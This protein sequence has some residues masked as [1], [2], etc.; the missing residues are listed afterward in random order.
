MPA[1]PDVSWPSTVALVGKKADIDGVLDAAGWRED[2]PAIVDAPEAIAMGEHPAMA[3]RRKPNSSISVALREVRSGRAAA[4][5][6]AGNSG[7]VMAGALVELGRIAGV[8]RPAIATVM[9]T[10]TG[11]TIL[12]DLGAVTDPKPEFLVQF[13]RMAR[14]YAQV[15]FG[16][17]DPKIALLSNGEEA[18]KGNQLAREAHALL[19]SADGITFIGNCEANVIIRG[20][21]DIIV[22]DGFT[23]NVTLKAIE[24]ANSIFSDLIRQ[25]L[26]ANL[27]RK[28]L[29]AGLRPA[30]RAIRRRFDFAEIGG[31]PL[32][33]VNGV[34]IIAHGRS[35]ARAIRNAIRVA[36][37]AARQ[38]LP[39]RIAEAL[40]ETAA[41]SGAGGR[42]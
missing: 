9:P 19:A 32:M 28:A 38:Q 7:A 20:T 27:A 42:S 16:V 13:A 15:Q 29:A 35:D 6:S 26:T 4:M 12:L 25:E 1:W 5:V 21:I 24:G 41:A 33:G 31:A 40:A 10:L 22:T 17:T 8:D 23:G 14:V 34:A 39:A 2:P 3:I 18:S 36:D 11:R 30:F 37:R